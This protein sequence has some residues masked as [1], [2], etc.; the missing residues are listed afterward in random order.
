[1]PAPAGAA[2]S[3]ST[4][5][6]RV[7][8]AARA[9][10]GQ[11]VVLLQTLAQTEEVVM[12]KITTITVIIKVITTRREVTEVI[13]VMVVVVT[14]GNNQENIN[15]IT[16]LHNHQDHKVVIKSMPHNHHHH[17]KRNKSKHIKEKLQNKINNRPMTSRSTNHYLS[18]HK[19][20]ERVVETITIRDQVKAI[21]KTQQ[22]RRRVAT[23][24]QDSKR[25]E[26]KRKEISD[27]TG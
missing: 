14:E 4:I 12:E 22:L 21:R 19:M 3:T 1:M 10:S 7:R 13:E 16:I 20:K 24:L 15:Q 8:L 9:G 25:Y 17:N 27:K 2:A 26:R 18:I 11:V 6:D 23:F 5:A